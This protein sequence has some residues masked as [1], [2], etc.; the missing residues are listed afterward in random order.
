MTKEQCA[1]KC[2]SLGCSPAE[3]EKCIAN[4]DENGKFIG[5]KD[6]K[7]ACCK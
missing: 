7:K 4:Y 3:K 5:K 2:D 1:A 6:A